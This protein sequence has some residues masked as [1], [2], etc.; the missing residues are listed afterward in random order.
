MPSPRGTAS[1]RTRWAQ[2]WGLR[3]AKLGVA[4][5]LTPRSAARARHWASPASG[6]GPPQDFGH[7]YGSSYFAAPDASRTPPLARHKDGLLVADLDLNLCQQARR[8][9]QPR[10]GR[11]VRMPA[12]LPVCAQLAS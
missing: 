7:F 12:G 3:G 4:T 6:P 10:S 11:R 9:P 2:T 8:R 5:L 1:R